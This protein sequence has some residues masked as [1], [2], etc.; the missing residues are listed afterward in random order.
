MA[1]DSAGILLSAGAMSAQQQVAN[2]AVSA[3]ASVSAY[4]VISRGPS[5]L[6]W[7]R[8]VVFT[9]ET[10]LVH[11]NNQSFVE[12][13]DTIEPLVPEQYTVEVRVKEIGTNGVF[14]LSLSNAASGLYIPTVPLTISSN[15]WSLVSTH[16]MLTNGIQ[17]AASEPFDIQAST[18][19]SSWQD[20]GD[21]DA[22]TNASQY[23]SR[24]YLAIPQ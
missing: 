3:A 10:G 22:D 6:V 21:F 24:F 14:G 7:Q 1:V 5:S 11:T 15:G 20:L 23:D 18:N 17:T 8:S 16:L 4:S 19:L 13:C 9:N 12:L 2:S